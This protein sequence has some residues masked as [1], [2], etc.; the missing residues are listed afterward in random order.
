MHSVEVAQCRAI[1]CSCL[2]CCSTELYTRR[3]YIESCTSR[4]RHDVNARCH[5][6]SREGQGL[7]DIRLADG[8]LDDGHRIPHPLQQ[9]FSNG[10]PHRAPV[11]TLAAAHHDTITLHCISN[12][13]FDCLGEAVL[14]HDRI[15]TC[16]MCFPVCRIAGKPFAEVD[17]RM[18]ADVFLINPRLI[19]VHLSWPS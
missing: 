3:S 8:V 10:R 11:D 4:S 12:D 13:A 1:Q 16:D 9:F 14:L 17:S 15:D 18:A 7:H 5:I 19:H 2:N 6:L